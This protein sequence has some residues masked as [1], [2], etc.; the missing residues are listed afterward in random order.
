[1]LARGLERASMLAQGVLRAYSG[2]AQACSGSTQDCSP[3]A[4]VKA[5]AGQVG[6]RNWNPTFGVFR[7][8]PAGPFESLPHILYQSYPTS[9]PYGLS[10]DFQETEALQIAWMKSPT[11]NPNAGAVT[12]A[13]DHRRRKAAQL[14][15]VDRSSDNR[16]W[17]TIA[18]PVFDSI[19][20]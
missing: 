6:G 18:K 4:Q 13:L 2:R 8:R 12:A 7:R 16:L 9:Q 3:S 19:T 15:C 5:V 14:K 17:K 1:M 10:K 20:L 11:E